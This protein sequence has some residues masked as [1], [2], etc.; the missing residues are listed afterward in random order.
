MA[1]QC[2]PIG[3][4]EA[5]PMNCHD[6]VKA[7]GAFTHSWKFMGS[8]ADNPMG[9]QWFAMLM[10]LGFVLSFGYWCTDFLVMQRAMAAESMSAARR[11]H[12]SPPSR[13]CSFL[14]SLFCPG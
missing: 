12:S 2:T 9:V 5:L 13:R 10:G 8:A 14:F 4:A 3:L 11:T 1:N 6:L 7:P